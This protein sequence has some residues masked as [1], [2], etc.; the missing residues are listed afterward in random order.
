MDNMLQ[1]EST[2]IEQDLLGKKHIPQHSYYGIHT[3]RAL[4]NFQISGLVVG[5]ESHFIRALAQV[6]K[7]AAQSNL[8]FQKISKQQSIAIQQACDELIQRPQDWKA[9]FPLDPYQGGAGTSVNM[10]ANEVIANRA[11]EL[12][13]HGKGEYQL[14]HP[15]DHVNTSQSTNDVYPTALRLATYTRIDELLTAL[16]SL[17]ESLYSKALEFQHVI[18]MGRTQ[19]QDAVP[20]TMEQEFRAFATL[21][22]EDFKLIEQLRQLLLEVNLGATAIGTGVN[23]PSGYAK[24]VI[25]NLAKITGLPL[26]QAE[27][28]V[29]ATSDCGA[30][31]IL[32]S[33]LKRLAVKLSKICNDLRLLSSGPRTGLAEIRLPELQAGSSI[34]PAKVNPVIPEV[35]NQIA[36]RVIGND[37]TITM[38]AE[39]GQL[40]LNVMEPVIAISLNESI[41]LLTQG[42][43]TLQQKC[44]EGI[45][46][47]E[48]NCLDAVMRSIGIITLL[49]PLLGHAACDEIGKQC[50]REN[51]TVPQVVLEL[52]LLTE[53]QL[54]EIFAFENLVSEVPNEVSPLEQVS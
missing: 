41:Q 36:F 3:L 10:N 5:Q 7:A 32:S 39:A 27:D 15:N 33:S 19:L 16:K 13:G 49:D 42:M 31:I 40:Q 25:E 29:E 26:K 34:M 43:Q 1:L 20:M 37:L 35:V 8:H 54:D 6:K 47:N 38:A 30:F 24:H 14:L 45:E 17:T 52:G 53:Q 11:L 2:R 44:I 51:K 48:Q 46:V 22:K 12:M 4:E 18:K 23:T 21:L 28:Y 9:S 50:I